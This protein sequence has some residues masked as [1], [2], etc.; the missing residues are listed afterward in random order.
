MSYQIRAKFTPAGDQPQ[1]IK[2]LVD[3]FAEQSQQVLMGVTGSGKTF[4]MA[5]VIYKTNLPTLIIAP[6]KTLAA[7]L[8]SEFKSFFPQNH[9]GFFI[10]YY[11]Y[12]QPEAYIPSSDTYIAK[13]SSIN[14]DIDKMRHQATK[15]IFENKNVIIIASV[16]CIYGLGSPET[17]AKKVINLKIN[18]KISYKNLI[19]KF[20]EINYER[21]DHELKRGSFR[22]RGDVIDILPSHSKDEIVRI[23]M[24]TDTIEN[25]EIVDRETGIS[26]KSL[27]EISLYPNSHYVTE[28]KDIKPIVAQIHED[29]RQQVNFLK[30]QKKFLES[31]RL[32]QRTLDDIE[33]LEQ[34]GFCP[35][36]ENYSRYLNG[37]KSGDPPPCLLDY[38]PEKFLT[39]IDES[40]IAIP[41]ISGMYKG[42]QARKKNL[43]QFGFRL[44]A[45]LD[46][47]PLNFS[48]FMEK[49]DKTLYVSATPAQFEKQIS[50][51]QIIEQVIRPTGLVDP[52]IEVRKT[53][54]QVD[55]LLVQI[56]QTI[57]NGGRILITTLTK[58]MAED[59]SA[60]Y[61]NLGLKVK[62]LHS[63]IDTLERSYLLSELRE[64]TFDSLIGINL[65]R[66]GLD[67]PEVQLVAIMDADKE[68]FLRS[69][70]SLIQTIG[71]ASRNHQSK[72][73]LYADKT[74]NSMKEAIDE[75]KRRR[76][77]Q[78][79]H[80]KKNNITPKTIYK[81]KSLDL[82]SLHGLS[83]T[84]NKTALS[85]ERLKDLGIC[86][87][88]K[89]QQT[90]KRKTSEL[91]KFAKKLEFEK[92]AVLRDELKELKICLIVYGDKQ[93]DSFKK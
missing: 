23:E 22:V 52:P 82:K 92:A 27:K 88:K 54:H 32:T 79:N 30:E 46:N 20:I 21:N 71:R 11:D 26:K 29:L 35:G 87:L 7:Q 1:A 53:E 24:F 28:K 2:S 63:D 44:P 31:E 41:Q 57:K 91:K 16:S 25:L 73:I 81:E 10:S 39:I 86:D 56:K 37:N 70:T 89:L 77:I 64:G 67:L 62:Y 19:R 68:G 61:Q 34:M 42:D 5:N 58:K 60:Y 36:I 85:L 47:R 15:M 75:T 17:Y 14:D 50:N 12:Y 33:A 65:L 59:L 18:E 9:V 40:H 90:I 3:G 83:D 80:N 72:V 74:T 8:Y 69:K 43:V 84:T 48:E 45:A 66:E 55:D 51:Y 13:D 6:N 76:Q 78:Q 49:I 93:D 4:T 38:F